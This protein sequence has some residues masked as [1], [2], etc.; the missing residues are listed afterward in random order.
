[1]A[2]VLRSGAL[3]GHHFEVLE[4]HI[5]YRLQA[6]IDLN[7]Y[8]M[9]L[10]ELSE[11]WFRKQVPERA[12]RLVNGTWMGLSGGDCWVASN[13]RSDH[14]ARDRAKLSH[15]MLEVDA[16]VSNVVNARWMRRANTQGSPGPLVKSLA[17]LWEEEAA[18][19]GGTAPTLPPVLGNAETDAAQL[20]PSDEALRQRLADLVEGLEQLSDVQTCNVRPELSGLRMANELGLRQPEASASQPENP[21]QEAIVDLVDAKAL[22]DA[23][24]IMEN[25]DKNDW[26][27]ASQLEALEREERAEAEN[28]FNDVASSQFGDDESVPVVEQAFADEIV[29]ASE[30]DLDEVVVML[31][32]YSEQGS[33][34]LQTFSLAEKPPSARDLEEYVLPSRSRRAYYSNPRDVQPRLRISEYRP[35]A[36]TASLPFSP[37]HGARLAQLADACP[38]AGEPL[39]FGGKKKGFP[40]RLSQWFTLKRYTLAVRPPSA[41]ELLKSV[42]ASGTPRASLGVSQVGTSVKPKWKVFVDLGGGFF[43]F[44]FSSWVLVE[45]RLEAKRCLGLKLPVL[46]KTCL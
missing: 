18:R 19:C 37:G 26:T 10:I 39:T 16:R 28:F 5:P 36:S 25:D 15:C 35:V 7:L 21:S 31:E 29:P 2:D 41:Q 45:K 40:C 23:L 22:V 46:A 32:E 17:V 34:A 43:F 14:L 13:V 38:M 44:L 30:H 6:C 20:G 27:V 12:E 1:M 24:L 8:G 4:A 9:D 42:N 33:Q 11:F 3:L